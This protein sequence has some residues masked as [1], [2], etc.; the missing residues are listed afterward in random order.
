MP[1]RT[2][3]ARALGAATAAL[4][5]LAGSSVAPAAA[6]VKEVKGFNPTACQYTD[7]KSET[8]DEINEASWHVKRLRPETAWPYAT[9]RGITVAVID[10]G[11]RVGDTEYFD[12]ELEH[13]NFAEAEPTKDGFKCSHGTRVAGFIAARKPAGSPRIFTG[14]APDTEVIS[15]R[16]LENDPN[17]EEEDG[18][19]S[20]LEQLAPT[21][22]GIQK[23]VELDVDII[24]ISQ[25]GSHTPAYAAAVKEAQDAGILVVASAGNNG[26]NSGASYPAAYPGVVAVGSTDFDDRPST[27][28]QSAEDMAI[29][30]AAPGSQVLAMD[31][32]G[33]KG[34]THG[35]VDGTSF[36]TPMVTGVAALIMERYPD[37]TP[38]EVK[39]RLETT[40]D[41]PGGRAVPDPIL[42]YGIVNPYRAMTDVMSLEDPPPASD[43]DKGA[44]HPPLKHPF[45]ADRKDTATLVA[46][47]VGG[48]SILIVL[49]SFVISHSLPAGRER[50]WKSAD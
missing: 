13:Y 24:N 15:M 16:A 33:P 20:E 39:R 47:G 32:S 28:S 7:F 48:G 1:H 45:D 5:L 19:K 23:A 35:S 42:G 8:D 3:L 36:A 11:V 25:S 40:A 29:S 30:V 18:E 50:K 41:T 14:I 38:A 9:G 17:E 27:F 34:Q 49:V 37:L 6:E 46:L 4:A 21:I 26:P 2:H 31:P 22:K 43:P 44:S 12:E 10:T